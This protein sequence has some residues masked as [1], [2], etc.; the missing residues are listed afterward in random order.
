LLRRIVTLGLSLALTLGVADAAAASTVVYQCGS[1][2]CAT[3]PAAPAP[4]TL[5]RDVRLA[6]IT[7]D[8]SAVAWVDASGN[9]VKAGQVVYTGSIGNEPQ[10]SPDGTQMLW[11]YAGPSV[12]IG[13]FAVYIDQLVFGQP[14]AG[15]SYCDCATTHGYLGAATPI[16]AFPAGTEGRG[17]PSE[18]CTLSAGG[19][20][21]SCVQVL[22][23]DA[24]GDLDFPAGSPDGQ[25]IVAAL[26]M[27]PGS[28]TAAGRLALYSATSGAL[29][30]DLT[31][32]TQ[33][34]TPQFSPDG[35][36]VVFDRAGQ[37]VTHDLQTGAEKVLGPGHYP[38]WGAGPSAPAAR[39]S[40]PHRGLRWVRGHRRL[41]VTCR[42]P[43]AG[44]CRV[45]ATIAAATARHL[46]L[47]VRR[48]ARVYALGAASRRLS[49][50]GKVTLAIRLSARETRALR[51]AHALK[52]TLTARSTVPGGNA[53]SVTVRHTFRG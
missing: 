35:R 14:T 51:R 22:A 26:A 36:S 18:I 30:R 4:R 11:W 13:E 39:L 25:L 46:G 8:G 28:D 42:L 17:S 7:R 23:T 41:P 31:T 16:A 27:P 40:V 12:F 37:I 52:V 33:D 49:R 2:V 29:V 15:V 6:G 10:M 1:D 38:F 53:R 9:V 21:S 43:A 5:A 3:D 45:R 20:S 19:G 44:T 24:R 32:G 50:A 48:H 47:R 34:T